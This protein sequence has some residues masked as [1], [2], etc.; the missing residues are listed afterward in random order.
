MVPNNGLEESVIST[1]PISSVPE[2]PGDKREDGTSTV[3]ID[4]LFKDNGTVT[5]SSFVFEISI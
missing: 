3:P 2:D 4:S 1:V 5:S